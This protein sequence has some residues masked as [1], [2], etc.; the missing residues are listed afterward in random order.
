MVLKVLH[1]KA[2]VTFQQ[3]MTS[4]FQIMLGSM[5]FAPPENE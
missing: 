4:L 1:F 3:A 2:A 5:M